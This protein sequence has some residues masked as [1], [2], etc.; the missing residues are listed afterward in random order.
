MRCSILFH[1]LVYRFLNNIAIL[2]VVWYA[3]AILPVGWP[4]RFSGLAR[5]STA[6]GALRF[7]GAGI[8]RAGRPAR[9]SGTRSATLDHRRGQDLGGG[10]GL[11]EAKRSGVCAGVM[12]HTPAGQARPD[13]LWG[14]GTPTVGPDVPGQQTCG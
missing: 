5:E 10:S 1:L 9:S 7:Q 4:C 2:A 12:D 13:P 8:G 14:S 3:T 6:R 11:P